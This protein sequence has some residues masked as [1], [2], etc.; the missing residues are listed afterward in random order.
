M[1]RCPACETVKPMT[2]F[3]R[4]RSKKD[5]LA[6]QCKLCKNAYD[7]RYQVDNLDKFR[8]ITRRYRDK[9]KNTKEY[10]LRALEKSRKEYERH[11]EA[12]LARNAVWRRIRSG[13]LPHPSTVPCVVCGDPAIEYDHIAGYEGLN[14]FNVEPVCQTDHAN[15]TRMRRLA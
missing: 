3:H 2:D 10:K 11:P 14:R 8:V 15:R 1:K 7:K 4:N 5:G 12:L 6:D 13:K 9:H